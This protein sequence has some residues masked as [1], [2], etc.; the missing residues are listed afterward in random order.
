LRLSAVVVGVL[1]LAGIALIACT[2]NTRFT[3]SNPTS[4]ALFVQVNERPPLKIAAGASAR[5]TLPTLE[6]LQPLNDGDL[7]RPP[8]RREHRLAAA[9]PPLRLRPRPRALTRRLST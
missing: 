2:T 6:R 3:L 1:V 7:D 4:G 5:V 8:R 9:R